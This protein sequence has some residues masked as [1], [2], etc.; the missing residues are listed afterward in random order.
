MIKWYTKGAGKKNTMKKDMLIGICKDESI[1]FHFYV[2][3]IIRWCKFIEVGVDEKEERLY[4]RRVE[5]HGY[6]M[7]KRKSGKAVSTSVKQ[8]DLTAFLKN[9]LGGYALH[10]AAE[11]RDLWYVDFNEKE[12]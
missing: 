11:E 7:Q 12:A 10:A 8:A 1:N 4:I 2:D 6:A 9:R 3:E 5:D